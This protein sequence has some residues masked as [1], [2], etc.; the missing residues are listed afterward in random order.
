MTQA[1]VIATYIALPLE[2]LEE[3]LGQIV[4]R[5]NCC[6]PGPAGEMLA[7]HWKRICE[8]V[9]RRSRAPCVTMVVCGTALPMTGQVSMS[10]WQSRI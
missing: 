6:R 10:L 5:Q 4:L 2:E 8:H 9:M 1:S 7:V 3:S